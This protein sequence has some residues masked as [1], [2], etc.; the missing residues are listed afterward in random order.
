MLIPEMLNE[1][2]HNFTVI[3]GALVATFGILG[4]G[5]EPL[6][7]FFLLGIACLIWAFSYWTLAVI[8]VLAFWHFAYKPLAVRTAKFLNWNVP[9]QV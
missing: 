7:G 9:D 4:L 5:E 6:A 1:N 2:L 8:V 3:L